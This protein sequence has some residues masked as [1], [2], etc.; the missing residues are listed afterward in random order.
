MKFTQEEIQRITGARLLQEGRHPFFDGLAID[1]RSCVKGKLFVALKGEKTDGHFFV[2]SAFDRGAFGA[3]IKEVPVSVLGTDGA[4]FQVED[5]LEALR[6]LGREASSRFR[7]TKIAITGT[8]GKT[9][10]K[11]FIQD[12]LQRRFSVEIT[13]Q[14][15]NTVIGVSCALANFQ[16]ESQIGVIEAGINRVGEMEELAEIVDPDI[17]IFTAFGAGHLEGLES[18]EKVVAEKSKLVGCRTHRVYLNG[19]SP[20]AASLIKTWEQAGKKV[21]LFG[22]RRENELILSSFTLHWP[23]LWADFSVQ[24][25]NQVLAFQSSM[26]FEEVLVSLLPALHVA[27]EWGVSPREIAEVLENWKPLPGRGDHFGYD[28]G[29]VIDD[30][31]NANPLSYRKA[32]KLLKFLSRQGLETWL[33]AGDMLELGSFSSEA[34]RVLLEEALMPPALSG[35]VIFG[36]HLREAAEQKFRKELQEGTIR[37]FSSH[38]EIQH[39]LEEYFRFRENWVVLFKGSRGMTMEKSIPE[40]WQTHHD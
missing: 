29:V 1:S 3:V 10:C 27:L 13:P 35:I 12:L 40:E 8:A 22:T 23:H 6:C 33:V 14:S 20:F 24:C 30:T 18:V 5:T 9:T 19:D 34:H 4:L 38:Q 7:G 39:F 11:H 28:G 32:L 15:F 37:F 21:I 17:V 25:G 31:Y 36:P 16:Q 2:L 26:L